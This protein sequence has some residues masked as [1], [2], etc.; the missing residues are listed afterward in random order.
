MRQYYTLA[1]YPHETVEIESGAGS[2]RH[3]QSDLTGI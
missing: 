2:G 3:K 1:D